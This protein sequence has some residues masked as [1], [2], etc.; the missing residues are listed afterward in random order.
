MHEHFFPL[1]VISL[2]FTPFLCLLA[3]IPVSSCVP[4]A[5]FSFILSPLLETLVCLQTLSS[6]V[7]EWSRVTWQVTINS[8]PQVLGESLFFFLELPQRY[9]RNCDT[10]QNPSWWQEYKPF[11]SQDLE[12]DFFFCSRCSIRLI[13]LCLWSSLESRWRKNKCISL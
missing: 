13:L 4:P 6:L 5:P 9:P 10:T 3:I 11:N 7:T 8:Q 2:S 12:R 1:S